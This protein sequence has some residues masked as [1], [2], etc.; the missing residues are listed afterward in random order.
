[1]GTWSVSW[2]VM[3]MAIWSPSA[4]VQVSSLQMVPNAWR[5]RA[6]QFVSKMMPSAF[7]DIVVEENLK[8]IIEGGPIPARERCFVINGWRW[9]TASVIRDLERFRIVVHAHSS[10][11]R[12]KRSVADSAVAVASSS[13]TGEMAT[14]ELLDPTST[15][16]VLGCF[17]FVCGFNWKALIKVEAEIFFPWLQKLLPESAVSLMSD[18]IQQHSKIVG[19]CGKMEA[20]CM[21]LSKLTAHDAQT[22]LSTYRKIE[23]IIQ[24]M[25]ACALKI[26]S[27]QE[28]VFVPYI[29]A[30]VSKSEQEVFNR[31][32]IKRLGLFDSQV[33]LVSMYEAIKTIPK[34]L[35]LY[36]E[37]IPSIARA[38]LPVWH[39]R[40]YLPKAGC[41]QLESL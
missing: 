3:A 11:K 10:I 36:E 28:S 41:L 25:Q 16:R 37:Q 4:I 30:F 22:E 31:M 15:A 7:R 8:S 20:Q 35:R 5:A 19:L 23:D 9:H 27:V 6:N 12:G 18:I 1:M 29:A 17:Q 24:D 34:E 13:T 32:V 39:K 14:V 26:Q 21:N 38:V 33:H 40:L 2:M